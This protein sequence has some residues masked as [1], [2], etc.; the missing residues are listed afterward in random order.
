MLISDRVARFKRFLTS[1]APF[2]VS[3]AKQFE[4]LRCSLFCWIRAHARISVRSAPEFITREGFT[5][6]SSADGFVS[7]HESGT[8]LGGTHS[9]ESNSSPG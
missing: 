9:L 3:E 8:P 1:Y 4:W 2:F 6:P 5:P 7:A